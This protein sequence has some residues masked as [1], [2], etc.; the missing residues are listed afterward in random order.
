MEDKTLALLLG[1]ILG[2]L[3]T[4]ALSWYDRHRP[5]GKLRAVYD[6]IVQPAEI[7]HYDAWNSHL[8]AF[9][10]ACS[11]LERI[12]EKAV[13]QAGVVAGPVEYRIMADLMVKAG[14]WIKDGPGKKR[15]WSD[16]LPSRAVARLRAAHSTSRIIPGL[17]P[18]PEGRPPAIKPAPARRRVAN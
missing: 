14:L 17:S 5:P 3:T 15:R 13:V 10:R 12:S 4:K 6:Q 2:V 8:L 18:Y 16:S 1:W 9:A 11:K 7:I